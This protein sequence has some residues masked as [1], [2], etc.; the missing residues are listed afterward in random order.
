MRAVGTHL[1]P[2]TSRLANFL[3]IL[4]DS[5]AAQGDLSG[6]LYWLEQIEKPATAPSHIRLLYERL[7]ASS[8]PAVAPSVATG[9]SGALTGAGSRSAQPVGAP[10][11][12]VLSA[13][14]PYAAATA[15]LQ[16][17]QPSP[18][19]VASSLSSHGGSP[20]PVPV[21]MPVPPMPVPIMPAPGA[22][23]PAHTYGHAQ[24]TSTSTAFPVA[25]PVSS[26]PLPM[27]STAAMAVPLTPSLPTMAAPAPAVVT[28]PVPSNPAAGAACDR[29]TAAVESL[30]SQNERAN[31]LSVEVAKRLPAL[32]TKLEGLAPA[33]TDPL[34]ALLDTLSNALLAGDAAQANSV[35]TE[36]Q[37]NYHLQLGS[38][39]MLALKRCLDLVKK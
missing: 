24:T 1:A 9:A 38:T 12:P 7:K 33:Q 21:P 25:A 10:L 16:A 22:V 26:A 23:A 6:A 19:P 3:S 31:K 36:A 17:R 34:V 30:G 27:R 37:Q 28:A 20:A 18:V 39:G 4:A 11:R 8:A 14:V 32:R 15:A 29:L 35:Y 5:L 13:P 2:N